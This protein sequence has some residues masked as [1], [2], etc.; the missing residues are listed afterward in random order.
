MYKIFTQA[1]LYL[2]IKSFK[3]FPFRFKKPQEKY[4]F[5]LTLKL[6]LEDE[7]FLCIINFYINQQKFKFNSEKK[8]LKNKPVKSSTQST[9]GCQIFAYLCQVMGGKNYK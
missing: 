4:L 3:T 7:K 2:N 6:R 5:K 9:L 8:L 1:F